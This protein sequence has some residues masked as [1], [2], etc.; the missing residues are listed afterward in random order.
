MGLLVSKLVG[1]H[2]LGRY[3]PLGVVVAEERDEETGDGTIAFRG[4]ISEALLFRVPAARVS[5]V[6]ASSRTVTVDADVGDFAPRLGPDGTVELDL[7]P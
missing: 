5:S 2:V 4:G 1:Y 6:S 3:G 7:G